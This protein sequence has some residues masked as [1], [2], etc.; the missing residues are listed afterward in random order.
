MHELGHLLT[1]HFL[2]Y[3][4]EKVKILPIGING[5]IKED[6]VNKTHNFIIALAGP[7]VN[8]VLALV[9]SYYRMNNFAI[10]NIYMLVLNLLPIM[11]LDGGRIFFSFYDD[12]NICKITQFC[13]YAVIIVTL[14]IDFLNYKRINIS[15]IWVILFTCNLNTSQRF[16]LNKKPGV[17]IV[18]GECCVLELLKN[19]NSDFLIYDGNRVVGILKY[20]DIYNAAID[21]LYYLNTKE[22][23]TERIK[24][25]HPRIR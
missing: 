12:E 14:L 2:G 7:C 18:S 24:N 20:E 22:L 10:C 23:I 13:A 4:V 8:L 5:K 21:G 1:A 3:S 15:L 9:A 17:I 11:P 25:G 19:K 16:K 6:I